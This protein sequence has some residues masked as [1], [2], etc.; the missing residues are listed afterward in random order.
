MKLLKTEITPIINS[1][2]TDVEDQLYLNQLKLAN[3]QNEIITKINEQEDIIAI[4]NEKDL[5]ET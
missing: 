2:R 4:L 1:L 3:K 5:E